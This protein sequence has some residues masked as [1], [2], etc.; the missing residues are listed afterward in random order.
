MH[1]S[2]TLDLLSTSFEHQFQKYNDHLPLSA[3]VPLIMS[4]VNYKLV[5]W[6][7][8]LDGGSGGRHYISLCTHSLKSRAGKPVPG[9]RWV[10]W[11]WAWW[12]RGYH[13]QAAR[14]AQSRAHTRA[15]RAALGEA[16]Q[17]P[18]AL[19]ALARLG[20]GPWTGERQDD[21]PSRRAAQCFESSPRCRRAP[22]VLFVVQ[23]EEVVIVKEEWGEVAGLESNLTSFCSD[24]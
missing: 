19:G 8:C 18:L 2:L 15:G 12:P 17:A 24:L 21:W 22:W 13:E 20:W 1:L 10:G 3:S 7:F 5:S 9:S 11:W 14:D 6:V 23:E 4:Q 16:P